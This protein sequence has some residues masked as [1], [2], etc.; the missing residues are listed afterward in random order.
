MLSPRCR[1]SVASPRRRPAGV[2]HERT[3]DGLRTT[4]AFTAPEQWQVT[5]DRTYARDEWLD[6]VPTS[7]GH[8]RFP[9]DRLAALLD[10][11]AQAIDA[12]GGSV[13]VR[14]TTTVTTAAR[15]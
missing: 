1:C 12:A 11:I 4:G 2:F 8:S 3:A 5:W 7:G 14:Y 10:G 13:V 6:Q 9:A 15:R